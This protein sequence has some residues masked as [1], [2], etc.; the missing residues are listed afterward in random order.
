MTPPA[1]V[2]VRVSA[3]VSP[4][5]ALVVVRV[6]HGRHHGL[7]LLLLGL[8]LPGR[9]HKRDAAGGGR[10]DERGMSGGGCVDD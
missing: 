8:Q 2:L 3:E 5:L 1:P 7:T 4:S 6:M 10:V 9:Q